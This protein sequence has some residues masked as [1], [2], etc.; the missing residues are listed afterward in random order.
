M[1]LTQN[2]IF[3]VAY[4]HFIYLNKIKNLLVFFEELSI[5]KVLNSLNIQYMCF[6]MGIILLEINKRI[7]MEFLLIKI[8]N[9]P[10]K[11]IGLI[12]S[13]ME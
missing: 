12:K 13:L 9:I 6:L 7:T 4:V 8:K 1:N 2:K 5:A 11:A 10:M 3:Q